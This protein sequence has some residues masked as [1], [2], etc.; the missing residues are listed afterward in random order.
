M[1]TLVPDD[2]QLLDAPPDDRLA[3]EGEDRRSFPTYLVAALGTDE[4]L[5]GAVHDFRPVAFFVGSP[6]EGDWEEIDPPPIEGEVLPE[7]V[8]AGRDVV[9]VAKPCPRDLDLD[10]DT[11]P[12]CPDGYDGLGLW[13]LDHRTYEWSEIA[14]AG[15]DAIGPHPLDGF[16]G[17]GLGPIGV[18][19]DEVYIWTDPNRVHSVHADGSVEQVAGWQDAIHVRCVTG[20]G[21]LVGEIRTDGAGGNG[22]ALTSTGTS[23]VAVRPPAATEW[24]AYDDVEFTH[25]QDLG[26]TDDAMVIVGETDVSLTTA[27][28]RV[29]G[30]DGRERG[31]TALPSEF[32][33]API[34]DFTVASFFAESNQSLVGNG[35]RGI[36]VVRDFGDLTIYDD[37]G[38]PGDPLREPYLGR[39]RQVMI[40]PDA[41][42]APLT[43]N[44][45]AERGV[46]VEGSARLPDGRIVVLVRT[47]GDR[48]STFEVLVAA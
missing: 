32:A 48:D 8:T 19:G 36:G 46:E 24:T 42:A 35:S 5:V 20:S 38:G 1:S 13:R 28:W 16:A 6:S 47:G 45:P 41:R 21:T 40:L 9:V 31:R 33:L 11:S 25:Q 4:V 30:L 44:Y 43:R 7:A 37:S 17:P 29:V 26:C 10:A 2:L 34:T 23:I 27:V 39:P 22:E 14:F 18:V 12:T 3:Q 15:A